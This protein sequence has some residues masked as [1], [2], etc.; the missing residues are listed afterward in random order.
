MMMSAFVL[1]SKIEHIIDT[2]P[3]FISVGLFL[4]RLFVAQC[5]TTAFEHEG[6]SP[7]CTLHKTCRVLSPPIPKFKA[8]SGLKCLDHTF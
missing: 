5:I 4:S 7:F 1:S 8:L 6:T 2:I 3:Y